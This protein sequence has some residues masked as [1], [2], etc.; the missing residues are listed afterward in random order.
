[1]D[2]L[3]VIGLLSLLISVF[4]LGLEYGH[5]KRNNRPSPKK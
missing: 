1:M 4:K 2:I 5:K 3:E